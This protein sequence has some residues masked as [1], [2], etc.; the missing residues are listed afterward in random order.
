MGPALTNV[1]RFLFVWLYA[2]SIYRRRPC[3]RQAGDNHSLAPCWLSGLLALPIAQSRRG[4]KVSA[5]LRALI[6]EMSRANPPGE[7]IVGSAAQPRGAAQAGLRG[8]PVDC[9]Q[10]HGTPTRAAIAS[11]LTDL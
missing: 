6:S 11:E 10:V 9:R 4:P 1:D 7:P 5:E 3:D 2:G 8:R